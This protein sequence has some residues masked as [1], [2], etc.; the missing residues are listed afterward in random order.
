MRNLPPLDWAILYRRSDIVKMFSR[1]LV[2]SD[3]Y[4]ALQLAIIVDSPEI[5][6]I[7]LRLGDGHNCYPTKD[8]V[9]F[10]MECKSCHSRDIIIKR[11]VDLDPNT[12]RTRQR[13]LSSPW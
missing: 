12:G 13:T 3:T 7:F 1:Y 8:L 2:R 11:I 9:Q 5:V 6:N 4:K 10:A